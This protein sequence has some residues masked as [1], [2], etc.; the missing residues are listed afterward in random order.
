MSPNPTGPLPNSANRPVFGS[1]TEAVERARELAPRLRARV[2]ETEQLRRL[3]DETIA[4]L[5]ASGLIGLEV[6][7]RWGGSELSLDALLEVTCEIAEACGSTGWVYCLWTAHMWLIGQFPLHVQQMVFENPNSLVSSAVN[8]TGKPAIVDGGYRWSGRGL[9]SSGVDHANWL[10]PAIE[11]QRDDGST[12]RRW[13]LIPRSEIEIV[14]D[15]HT[16]GL[17][18]T[19]SK[20]FIVDDVFI[21][22]ERSLNVKQLS[23]GTAPGAQLHNSPLYCAAMEFTFSLPVAMPEVGIARA[24]LKAFEQRVRSRLGGDNA[25]LAEEQLG[26]LTRMA[27]AGAEIDAAHALLLNDSERFCTMAAGDATSLDRSRCRRDVSYSA[28]L[29]RQAVNS[30]FE[31]SGGSSI[32]DSADLQRL[33]RDSNVA[34]AHHGLFWDFHGLAYAKELINSPTSAG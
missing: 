16:V 27:K 25:K 7:K 14:D 33:W 22:E 15:W 28:Q 5:L 26:T 19:G 12:E 2:S 32:Y 21:P 30:L 9:F 23:E 29:C 24:V 20:T 1:I 11:F 6:P 3:P 10:T 31:A 8:T 18:G 13:F 17:K 4:D 34:A